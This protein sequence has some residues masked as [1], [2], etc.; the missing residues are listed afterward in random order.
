MTDHVL[1]GVL[2]DFIFLRH[3]Y[4]VLSTIVRLVCGIQMKV[5]S[6]CIVS[7]F[8]FVIRQR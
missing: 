4:K 2:I 5:V 7:A 3:C 8:K 1:D 6:N